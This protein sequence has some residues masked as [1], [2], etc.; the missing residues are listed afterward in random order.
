MRGAAEYRRLAKN[1]LRGKYSTI[2]GA[3]ILRGGIE[4]G[5]IIALLVLLFVTFLTLAPMAD[6]G[7]MILIFILLVLA[8][9]VT[10]IGMVFVS[11]VFQGG[12]VRLARCACLGEE[13]K[14]GEL[15]YGFKAGLAG[16]LIGMSILI[17]L[18]GLP[19]TLP[20]SL[21]NTF[22]GFT[23]LLASGSA[24]RQALLSLIGILLFLWY[25]AGLVMVSLF[26]GLSVYILID[27]PQLGAVECMKESL[28]LTKGRRK[29]LFFLWLGYA[30]YYIL[31]VLSGGIGFLWVTPNIQ[32]AL[33]YFYWDLRAEKG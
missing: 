27:R 25:M 6:V 2:V 3:G 8:L 16:R 18:V 28:R 30:G 22:A 21:W 1:A 24:G 11:M 15:F 17:G 4:I 14:I 19:F 5:F 29:E 26:F 7:G 9:T 23:R 20:Y 13:L 32:C 12:Q 10:L 33:Y 31:G